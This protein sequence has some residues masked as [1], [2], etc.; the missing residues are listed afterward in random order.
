[1]YE[2]GYHAGV[3]DTIEHITELFGLSEDDSE[4]LAKQVLKEYGV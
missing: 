3:S 2:Q 4:A 1:M